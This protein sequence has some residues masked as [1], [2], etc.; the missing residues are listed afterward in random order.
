VWFELMLQESN[1]ELD[2]AIR[3]YYRGRP[4]ARRGE[5]E[6]Y[7][8]HVKRLRRRC[9]RNEESPPAW[10][11]LFIRALNDIRRSPGA[12]RRVTVAVETANE[13]VHRAKRPNT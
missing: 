8:A 6:D 2:V 4:V 1:G 3:A 13:T 9:I 5:G 7:L 10:N 11:T 12:S